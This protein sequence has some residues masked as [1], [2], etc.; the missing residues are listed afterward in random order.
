MAREAQPEGT[1]RPGRNK[2][3]FLAAVAALGVLAV[4]VV[5]A[6]FVPLL[7]VK[8]VKVEGA[9]HADPAAVSESAEISAGDNMLRVDTAG[10]AQ[11]VSQV[12]WI[13]KVT[14]SRSWPNTISIEVVENKA[15]GYVMDGDTPNAV[16]ADGRVF[17][18]GAQPEG[19]P[20]FERAKLEDT[21]AIAAAAE[22]VAALPDDLRGQLERVEVPDAESVALFFPEGREVYWGSS[23][24]AD[25]KAEATRIVLTRE[26]ARWNV[27][28]PAMPTVRDY[29]PPPAE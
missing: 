14:V 28:N 20:E 19:V 16:S 11:R 18:Q 4:L 10:A 25:E 5:V 21:A 6:Y 3:V 26:G 13:D 17:L 23:E 8:E 7:S 15:V 12:P 22:A 29:V 2:K 1:A 24:R 9:Q 27:S